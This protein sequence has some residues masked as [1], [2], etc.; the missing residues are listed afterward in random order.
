MSL[1]PRR[2]ECAQQRERLEVDAGERDAGLLAR[3]HVALDELA[4]RDDEQDAL[5]R[6]AVLVAALTEDVVVEHRLVERDRKRLLR[7]EADRVLELLLVVD[8]HEVENADADA[9]AGD[10]EPHVLARKLVLGEELLQREGEC[11]GIAHFAADDDAL[12]ERL[13]RHLNELGGP[14]VDDTRGRELRRADL[15]ADE[16]LDR[17]AAAGVRF[18]SRLRE[19]E[20]HV[21]E[22]RL[23][24]ALALRLRR[25]LLLRRLGVLL[26]ELALPDGCLRCRFGGCRLRCWRRRGSGS[27]RRLGL[28]ARVRAPAEAPGRRATARRQAPLRPRPDAA[29]PPRARGSARFAPGCGAARCPCARSSRSS[30]AP[31]RRRPCVG[32]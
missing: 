10:A 4:I 32:S 9:V 23:R 22:P 11:F 24:L 2:P 28:E 13:A 21:A 1:R 17:M 27:R 3:G 5:H 6:S 7:A 31:R 8:A 30:P 12:L 16:A 18:R 26:S 15:Q 29:P 20:L 25:L 14:V 19:R